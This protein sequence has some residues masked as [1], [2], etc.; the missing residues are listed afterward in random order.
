MQ[1]SILDVP[2]FEIVRPVIGQKLEE[3]YG[4]HSSQIENQNKYTEAGVTMC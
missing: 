3:W 1:P 4:A 2:H